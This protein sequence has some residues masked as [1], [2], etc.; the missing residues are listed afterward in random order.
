MYFFPSDIFPSRLLFFHG[1][2]MI[3]FQIFHYGICNLYF[4]V[5]DIS[6]LHS[7]F[8]HL[9]LYILDEFFSEQKFCFQFSIPS[10]RH[11]V[12]QPHW[13]ICELLKSQMLTNQC[14]NSV[15]GTESDI[16]VHLLLFHFW[17]TFKI[18]IF[19]LT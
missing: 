7:L 8:H 15:P 11:T 4:I 16:L 6:E 12:F 9:E 18:S 2:L 3:I 5:G 13:K 14:S 19:R 10:V 1:F 17:E